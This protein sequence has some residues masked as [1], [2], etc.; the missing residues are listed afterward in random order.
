ML[1]STDDSVLPFCLSQRPRKNPPK[2]WCL[3]ST[4]H[5]LNYESSNYVLCF[6]IV[7]NWQ[8]KNLHFDLGTLKNMSRNS[9]V[10]LEI[11]IIFDGR[12]MIQR[13]ARGGCGIRNVDDV[14]DLIVSFETVAIGNGQQIM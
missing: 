1:T 2:L 13:D 7:A 4:P 12:Q 5:L 14:H 9:I 11:V 6:V 8:M 10:R 3:P